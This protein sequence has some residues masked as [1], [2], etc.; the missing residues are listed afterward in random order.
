MAACTPLP[1]QHKLIAQNDA[2]RAQHGRRALIAGFHRALCYHDGCQGLVGIG[3]EGLEEDSNPEPRRAVLP[4]GSFAIEPRRHPGGATKGQSVRSRGT[5]VAPGVRLGVLQVR[6]VPGKGLGL[7]AGCDARTRAE[8]IDAQGAQ[9]LGR[10]GPRVQ[11]FEVQDEGGA[12]C[13]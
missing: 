1:L 5:V 6:D 13:C 11:N 7:D 3:A 10:V 8:K 9:R 4:D 2:H 12:V